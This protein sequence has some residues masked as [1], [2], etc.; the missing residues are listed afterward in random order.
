MFEEVRPV[1]GAKHRNSNVHAM[2]HPEEEDCDVQV[3]GW[4]NSVSK[5]RLEHELPEQHNGERQ[6]SN[7]GVVRTLLTNL[8]I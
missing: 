4:R 5:L 3:G 7:R 8:D 1:C 6:S 2:L